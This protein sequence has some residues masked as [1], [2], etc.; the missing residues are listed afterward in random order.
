MFDLKAI[1][2]SEPSGVFFSSL[3]KPIESKCDGQR[4]WTTHRRPDGAPL[5]CEFALTS[6]SEGLRRSRFFASCNDHLEGLA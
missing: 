5:Y 2:T 6:L 1:N 3:L 4:N